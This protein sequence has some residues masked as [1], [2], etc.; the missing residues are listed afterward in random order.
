M[1]IGSKTARL[2]VHVN[3]VNLLKSNSLQS[4]FSFP[5]TINL[6]A[7]GLV[8]YFVFRNE[9]REGETKEDCILKSDPD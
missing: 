4:F 1:S 6:I 5:K 3:S 8:S 2:G 7:F 9:I